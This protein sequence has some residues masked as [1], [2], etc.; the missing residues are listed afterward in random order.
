M[1]VLVKQR[2][3]GFYPPAAAAQSM[4]VTQLPS[5]IIAET[6]IFT[7]V[8]YFMSGRT[9]ADNLFPFFMTLVY[10]FLLGLLSAQVIRALASCFDSAVAGMTAAG[11]P[12]PPC[13]RLFIFMYIRLCPAR[14]LILTVQLERS[15]TPDGSVDALCGAVCDHVMGRPLPT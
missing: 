15:E 8:Y 3:A 12:R 5:T 14:S 6:L 2:G 10:V 13:L 11:T 1:H 9:T 7:T 4:N